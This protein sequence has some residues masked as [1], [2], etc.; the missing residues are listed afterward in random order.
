MPRRKTGLTRI[1]AVAF[2][3]ISPFHLAVPCVVF[4][5]PHPGAPRFDFRVCAGEAGRLRTTAG[6]AL[7]TE[8]GLEAIRWAE[9]VI[10]PSWRDPDEPPPRPLLQALRR[11]HARGARLVGL[12]LGAYVLA[13]AGLLEGRRATTHWS[14]VEDFRQRFPGV[15]VDP[16]VLY[17]DDGDI[18]TSAG[19]A[20][21]LDCCLH[22]VR[23][24]HGAAAASCIARRLVVAP[25]RMGGQAQFIERPVPASLRDARF[26]DLLERLRARL[27]E[28]H[29]LSSMAQ[30]AAMSRRN[31]SRHFR[32]VT[33]VSATRWLLD[34]R[35]A[36]SQRLLEGSRHPVA[37]VATLAGFGTT[38]NLR[39]HFRRA[40]GVSPSQWRQSFSSAAPA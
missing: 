16:D 21:G 4:G 23:E 37:K 22:L 33:G 39:Q 28:P 20:A 2:D 15:Q 34:E 5:D 31:F 11:A 27:A 29:T 1:A 36:L 26:S 32:K 12:C 19:T 3:N 9:V 7:A 18:V 8:H 38:V 25:H 24:A 40:F 30:E 14:V 35:L 13:A 6:F 17:V 10:V